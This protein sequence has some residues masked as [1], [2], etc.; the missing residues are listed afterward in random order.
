M[1]FD[2]CLACCRTEKIMRGG[3]CT[4][5]GQGQLDKELSKARG[6]EGRWNPSRIEYTSFIQVVCCC[7]CKKNSRSKSAL[8]DFDCLIFVVRQGKEHSTPVESE[9]KRKTNTINQKTRAYI[10]FQDKINNLFPNFFLFSK[11]TLNWIINH[12]SKIRESIYFSA[13]SFSQ[14]NAMFGLLDN[15]TG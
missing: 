7:F 2:Y 4:S 5:N 11:E 13:I 8:V 3:D 1:C 6:M 15:L 12:R 10:T 9:R 14:Y